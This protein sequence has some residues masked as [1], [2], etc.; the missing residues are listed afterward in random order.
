MSS[1]KFTITYYY[2][3][4][5]AGD[6]DKRHCRTAIV[7]AKN[8][9]D[10]IDKIKAFDGEYITVADGGVCINELGGGK[11]ESGSNVG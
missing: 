10:A 5:T 4:Y 8:L 2:K 6:I 9:A 1:A 7:Y 11:N 3:R